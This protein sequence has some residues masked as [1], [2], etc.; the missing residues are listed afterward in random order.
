[1][2]LMLDDDP[3]G[4]EAGDST[5]LDT[6]ELQP[7]DA[8]AGGDEKVEL[9]LEDAPFLEEEEEPVEEPP[10][11]DGGDGSLDI[12]ADGGGKRKSGFS[13]AALLRDRRVQI[14]G[15]AVLLLLVG[16]LI[17]LLWPSGEPPAE[18]QAQPVV[19]KKIVRKA[20]ELP[21]PKEEEPAKPEYVVAWEPF[22][23]EQTDQQG[24]IRFLVCKFAAVTESERLSWEIG[25]KKVV[26]RDAI[27]YYL[28]NKSLLF[29]TEK[30]NVETLKSDLLAV[31]NQYL[32]NGQLQ[33][34]LI[35]NY[36]VK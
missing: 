30:N 35:E 23:V 5:Q 1:M 16:L 28:R 3:L 7:V 9:D 21:P 13:A 27:F 2:L 22:W 20:G 33:D 15:G 18:K 4:G 36:L 31:I 29:L 26:L 19:K 12:D 32:D 11:D 14:G 10:S 34:L 8:S 25:T 24:N 6:E 17:F